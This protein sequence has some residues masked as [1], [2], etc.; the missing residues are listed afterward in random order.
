MKTCFKHQKCPSFSLS[1]LNYFL[2]SAS[3][4]PVYNNFKSHLAK[5][6]YI[7][8]PNPHLHSFQ[9]E[10]WKLW[11]K[12]ELKGVVTLAS[13]RF[14]E[15]M[16][17]NE[18]VYWF[19]LSILCE[20]NFNSITLHYYFVFYSS[21]LRVVKELKYLTRRLVPKK[22]IFE[23]KLWVETRILIFQLRLDWQ[24]VQFFH[25]NFWITDCLNIG[26]H[27]TDFI[28]IL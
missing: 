5:V 19:A 22:N 9:F 26:T 18:K 15:L 27:D 17:G 23:I 4:Y 11:N 21:L 20:F 24:N 2:Q 1:E 6:T 8:S 12:Q 25:E 10:S 14:L 3:G 28:R 7:L 16:P 13:D